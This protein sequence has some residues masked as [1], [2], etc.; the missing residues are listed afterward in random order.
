VILAFLAAL[1]ALAASP[2][3]ESPRQFIARVYAGYARE[4][5]SPLD[6]PAAIFAPALVR[7]IR[8]DQRLAKGEVGYLDGDPLC[9]CQDYGKLTAQV[10][11]LKR[12]T[13]Q[14]ADAQVHVD[15][16]IGEARDLRLKL[17]LTADG[18][19]VA[20]VGS[21]DEPSLL[22]AIEK[23]NRQLRASPKRR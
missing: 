13:K 23:S 22:G 7:E 5:Y 8:E 19:R 15:L 4:N 12:P 3:A 17:V 14:S 6:K 18:W 21:K 16:G 2:R 10:R 20:D 9:D 11:T 1:G